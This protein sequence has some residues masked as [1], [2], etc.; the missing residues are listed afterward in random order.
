MIIVGNFFPFLKYSF[1]FFFIKLMLLQLFI[2]LIFKKIYFLDITNTNNDICKSDPLHNY[3][4]NYKKQIKQERAL[5]YIKKKYSHFIQQLPLYTHTHEYSNKIFWCWLDGE[6]NAPKLSKA[7]L[8]SIRKKCKKHE[9]IV[10]TKNNLNQFISLPLY[11][12]NKFK[13]KFI[14]PAHFCDLIRLELLIKYGGTW[15]D[16]SVLLTKYDS[17][18]FNC[19]LFFFH[20]FKE[21][22][23]VGSNWFLTS[24]KN[25][26]ILKTTLDLLYNFWK[27]NDKIYNYYIFHFFFLMS[28][29][30]YYND[31]QKVHNYSNI[32]AHILQFELFKP[33]QL[34]QYKKILNCSKVHKLT[35]HQNTNIKNGLFYHH[36]IEDY[37]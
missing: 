24:E 33:F 27:E 5:K 34:N 19:D 36:I 18:F 25:N 17:K 9:I 31:C 3:K 15:I 29:Q 32:P 20:S 37:Q 26:P 30:K 11:I 8:V 21:K 4:G 7:C 12:L 16:S 14:S 1:L 10:I 28:C 2:L 6:E 35:I 22:W 23:T 13:N